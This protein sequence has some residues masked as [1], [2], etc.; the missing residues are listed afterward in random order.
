M[1][2]Y[3][4][5]VQSQVFALMGKACALMFEGLPNTTMDNMF[6]CMVLNS[7]ISTVI[8]RDKVPQQLVN[9]VDFERKQ[10]FALRGMAENEQYAGRLPGGFNA[11]VV[12]RMGTYANH[13]RFLRDRTTAK[14]A[15]SEMAFNLFIGPLEAKQGRTDSIELI[16]FAGTRY[17][18]VYDF[19][20]NSIN[21][22]TREK[23]GL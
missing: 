17:M 13:M 20:K 23:Y 15:F 18:D 14:L 5:D 7:C 3:P 16:E 11:F 19:L 22:L 12:S 1:N 6:E 10:L 4:A 21:N 8:F 9:E 2:P